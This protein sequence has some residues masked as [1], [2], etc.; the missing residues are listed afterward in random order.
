M[1][2]IPANR[3]DVEPQRGL[4]QIHRG[5][6]ALL[7]VVAINASARRGR[8]IRRRRAFAALFEEQLLTRPAWNGLVQLEAKLHVGD[9][10]GR[11]HQLKGVQAR[12]QVPRHVVVPRGASLSVGKALLLP[13]RCEGA[14]KDCETL[15]VISA[16]Y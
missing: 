4:Q 13:F 2:L 8:H 5:L 14:Y 9:G 10:I 11:H 12:K 3:D 7:S 1:G 15:P 16:V 6:S